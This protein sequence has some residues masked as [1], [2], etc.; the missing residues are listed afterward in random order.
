MD[1]EVRP[2]R[3]RVVGLQT[4]L[5]RTPVA[6]LEKT[7]D[8]LHHSSFI[9]RSEEMCSGFLI[10]IGDASPTRMVS[11]EQLEEWRAKY[12]HFDGISY[13][14]FDKNVGTSRGHN[15]LAKSLKNAEYLIFSNPDVV[16]DSRAI[17]RMA[18]AFNDPQVGM[19]EAKQLPIEHPKDYDPGTG[20]TS[21]ATTAFAM[22]PR[23]LFDDL[24]GFDAKTFFMYCD[25]LDYSWRVREAG[26]TVIFQPAAVV[27]HDKELTVEGKWMPTQAERTYS[28]Q[29][30]L[31]LAHKWSRDDVVRRFVDAFR[32]SKQ[33]EHRAALREFERR[34]RA[35]AL[36]PQRDKDHVIGTFTPRAFTKHRY[37][38]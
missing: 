24:G 10:A 36:V 23:E 19:V 32:E 13:R 22:T 34:K 2:S 8:A 17:W 27:F 35:G 20:H 14:F 7:L 9:G 21:W 16:P 29:A 4:L 6:A 31:L 1:Q 26:R 3:P 30:A 15:A 18:A 5:Y 25:D 28:A 12:Q 11:D 37:W 38:L 33:P